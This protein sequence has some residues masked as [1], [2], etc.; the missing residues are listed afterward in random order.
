MAICWSSIPK[1]VVSRKSSAHRDSVSAVTFAGGNLIVSGSRDADL[2][3]W[4]LQDEGSLRGLLTLSPFPI[5]SSH[6]RQLRM[7]EP[8]RC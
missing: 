6:L 7:E 1:P 3:L 4:Q 2:K 5:R 8:S